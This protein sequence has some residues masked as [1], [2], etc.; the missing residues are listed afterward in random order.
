MIVHLNGVPFPLELDPQDAENL[1]RHN[2]RVTP[3]GGSIQASIYSPE[4]KAG[5]TRTLEQLVFRLAPSGHV[6]THKN[7]DRRDFRRKNLVVVPKGQETRIVTEE[8]REKHRANVLERSRVKAAGGKLVGVYAQDTKWRAA[9]RMLDG[10]LIHLG[11]FATP[12]EAGRAY[13]AARVAQ[14]YDAIN[15]PEQSI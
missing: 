14:G 6:I 10:K 3:R 13:D 8:A 1:S 7:G 5:V 12:E 2:Y 9:L 15:F 11:R 4:K